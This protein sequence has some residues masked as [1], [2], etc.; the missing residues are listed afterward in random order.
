MTTFTI[1]KLRKSLFNVVAECIKYGEPV[2]ISTKDGNAVLLSEEEYRGILET[3]YICSVPGM[4]EKILKAA[5]EPIS[6][7][8]RVTA[9]DL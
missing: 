5:K 2:S 3:A 9:D 1:T 8:K 4:K 6:K 7:C